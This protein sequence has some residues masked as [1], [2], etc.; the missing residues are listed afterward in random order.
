MH[1]PMK[2]WATVLVLISVNCCQTYGIDDA[3]NVGM[4]LCDSSS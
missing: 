2:M 1:E 4:L 3:I